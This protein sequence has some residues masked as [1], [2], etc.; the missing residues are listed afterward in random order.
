MYKDRLEDQMREHR[1]LQADI[2]SHKAS[3][4]S[5]TQSAKELI[6]TASNP[7]LAK[8]IETKLRDVISRYIIFF[9][10][11][12]ILNNFVRKN[13]DYLFYFYIY[14]YEK[15]LDKTIKRGDLLAQIYHSLTVF[16]DQASSLERWLG[17]ALEIIPE[18]SNNK[19][20]DLIAQRD[21][22]KQTL[23]Q[24]IQDGKTLINHKDVTDT[25]Y[26]RDRIK[27]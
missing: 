27:V 16:N 2:D 14:R 1:M 26:L 15:L 24:V 18:A 19:I 17:E 9:S 4:D 8:K 3:V 5:V 12:V 10:V 21:T 22:L 20:E 23:D 6:N 25:A 7:R 11:N 13:N